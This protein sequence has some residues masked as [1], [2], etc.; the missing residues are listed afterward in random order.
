MGQY[1]RVIISNIRERRIFKAV[2]GGKLTEQA[3][4]VILDN[5][6]W[7]DNGGVL[8]IMQK[9]E[10]SPHFVA[11]VGDYS[12]DLLDAIPEVGSYS[13]A[14]KPKYQEVWGEEAEYMCQD[15]NVHGNMRYLLNISKNL[16]VD[17]QE[18]AEIRRNDKDKYIYYSPLPLLTAVGNGRGG[19]D[20]DLTAD[21]ADKVGSWVWDLIS[22]D[23]FVPA[24]FK[25]LEVN[26]K[27]ER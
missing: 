12:E 8:A 15:D 7:E 22:V 9:L 5:G 3:H 4:G 11:W 2:L 10:Y 14:A 19:G 23:S 6:T 18:L 27:E 21:D 17:L 13:Y 20:Y 26:F 25:K 24:G 1:Y 16:Y